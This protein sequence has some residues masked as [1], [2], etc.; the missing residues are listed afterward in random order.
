MIPSLNPILFF[1]STLFGLQT[2]FVAEQM[3][4]TIDFKENI[5][6]IKYM[7]LSV[8]YEEENKDKIADYAKL[9]LKEIENSTE[10]DSKMKGLELMSSEFEKIDGKLNVK[11]TFS[12][13]NSDFLLRTLFFNYAPGKE[14][15][16]IDKIYYCLLHAEE[17]VSSNGTAKSMKAETFIEWDKDTKI[18]D[19][20]LKQKKMEEPYWGGSKSLAE[21]WTK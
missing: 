2:P 4:V 8:P 3:E 11:I 21:Y 20:Q 14:S 17:L 6:I 5:A 1:L 9:K 15:V 16:P 13:S 12:F 10:F 18:I 7:D 19:L